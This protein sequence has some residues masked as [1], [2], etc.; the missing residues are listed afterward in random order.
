MDV[1]V[2]LNLDPPPEQAKAARTTGLVTVVADPGESHACNQGPLARPP[3]TS[4][5]T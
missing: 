5:S 2:D 1:R 4:G 3:A